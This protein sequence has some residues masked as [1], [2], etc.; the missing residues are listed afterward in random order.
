MIRVELL[1]DKGI[2]IVTPEGKLEASDFDRIGRV[3]DPYINAN[4]KLSGLMICAAAFPGWSDFAAL[5]SHIRF[6]KGHHRKINRV[7]AVTDSDFVKIMPIV[8]KHFVAAELRH[9]SFAE[10]E[11]ALTW[12][13][14]V[15]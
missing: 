7:A 15:P 5:I 9:F 13:E 14:A 8:A 11:H 12:L 6:I 10:K 2:V 1:K 3:V 4:G